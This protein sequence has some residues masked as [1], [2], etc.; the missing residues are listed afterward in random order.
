[1]SDIEFRFKKTKGRPGAQI[2]GTIVSV[3]GRCWMGQKVGDT[4]ELDGTV[5]G[6]LCGHLYH[7]IYPYLIMLEYGGGFP[8]DTANEWPGSQPELVC[9]DAYNQVRIQLRR[10]G[11]PEGRHPLYVKEMEREEKKW[12]KKLGKDSDRRV[13]EKPKKGQ[14]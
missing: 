11:I 7:T 12:R 13:A 5:T 3:T 1:M 14:N 6:G 4:F 10:G 2:I 9:P 8:N